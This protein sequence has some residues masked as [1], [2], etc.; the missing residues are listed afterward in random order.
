MMQVQR[1]SLFFALIG[2]SFSANSA[3]RSPSS[4]EFQVIMLAQ[5]G[6]IGGTIGKQR[7]SASGGEEIT[8]PQQKTKKQQSRHSGEIKAS[9]RR[10]DS[11]EGTSRSIKAPLLA[12]SWRWDIKC[13]TASFTGQ[14]NIVQDGST[15]TGEFGH[16]NFWDNGTVSNGKFHG[17]TVTFDREYLG[18]DHVRLIYS[19][20]THGT[21]MKGPHYNAVWG[22]CSIF[23]RKN[24]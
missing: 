11:Q 3:E 13:P 20:S 2:I 17:N 24:D 6:S 8:E 14:M 9:S 12:G 1:F 23:A 5:A 10:E 16:T 7:K 21:I 22:Q 18:L 4:N 15:F 19:R